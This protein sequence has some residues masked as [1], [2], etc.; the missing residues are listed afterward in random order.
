MNRERVEARADQRQQEV[1]PLGRMKLER[2]QEK[3]WARADQRQ[4]AIEATAVKVMERFGYAIGL[5]TNHLDGVDS[6]TRSV[7]LRDTHS[8]LVASGLLARAEAAEAKLAELTWY[9]CR[10]DHR[11]ATE[12]YVNPGT[13]SCPRCGGLH[14]HALARESAPSSERE[15][16]SAH[17]PAGIEGYRSNQIAPSSGVSVEKGDE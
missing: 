17:G 3:A 14:V 6:D 1:E 8:I 7:I 10:L 16:G 15:T 11:W 2:D 4:Q 12:G 5:R 13:V 9:E